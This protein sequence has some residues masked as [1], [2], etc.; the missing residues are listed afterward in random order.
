MIKEFPKI[1]IYIL[2][3]LFFFNLI[4]VLAIIFPNTVIYYTFLLDV[5]IIVPIYA[6]VLG[7][8]VCAINDFNPYL[9]VLVGFCYI[10]TMIIFYNASLLMFIIAYVIIN[11]FGC[12]IGSKIYKQRTKEE[13]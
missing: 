9:P 11:F 1:L 2:I 7:I 8:I 12:I 10:P 6:F 4:P 5:W 3:S 13:Y